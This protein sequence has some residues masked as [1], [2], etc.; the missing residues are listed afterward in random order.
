MSPPSRLPASGPGRPTP[1]DHRRRSRRCWNLR[2]CGPSG[3]GKSHLC[4]ALTPRP[5]LSHSAILERVRRRVADKRVLIL[6]KAFLKAGIMPAGGQIR[7]TVT[8]TP[9]GGILSPLIANIALSV[10][11]EH[12]CAKWDAHGDSS[13]RYRHRKRGGA[14]VR[15][16]RYADTL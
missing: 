11:D 9:Q 5:R 8:G 3:I 12:F 1:A 2:V 4:E 6:I 10:L 15:C 16:V 14:T 7:D 13:A